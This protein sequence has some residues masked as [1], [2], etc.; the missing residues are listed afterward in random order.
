VFGNALFT[1]LAEWR[2]RLPQ[3]KL[4]LHVKRLRLRLLSVRL[5]AV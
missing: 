1:I 2:G 3:T 4:P 5:M